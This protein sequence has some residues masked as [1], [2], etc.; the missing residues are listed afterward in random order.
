MYEHFAR[1]TFWMPFIALVLAVPVASFAQ[2]AQLAKRADTIRE[3]QVNSEQDSGAKRRDLVERAAQNAAP[4]KINIPSSGKPSVGVIDPEAI[5]RQYAQIKAAPMAKREDEAN[6]LMLFVS[7]SMPKGSLER[8]ARD[9]KKASST[10]VMRGVSK[11]VGPGKWVQSM[12][13]LEPITNTGTAVSLDPDLFERYGIKRVPAV[14]VAA[15]PKA[16]CQEDACREYAVVYGD[17]TLAYALERLIDR[18]DS[19]GAIARE[20]LAKLEKR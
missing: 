19:I 18:K 9:A 1:K 13:A 15:D 3:A 5:A 17:V 14:V 8:A 11:G 16:G 2:S 10:I 7:L 20:R 6:E 12:T 4:T